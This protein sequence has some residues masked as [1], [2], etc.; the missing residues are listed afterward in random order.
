MKPLTLS[1]IRMDAA[2]AGKQARL[3]RAESLIA[4]A[5]AQGAQMAVLP[6][7]FNTGY[8]YL[9][10]NYQLAE[11]LDGETVH[12][13]KRVARQYNLHV[14][15]TF[16]LRE[17]DGLY[18]AM[19]LIAPDGRV[20]RY[21]KSH[22]W[23]WERAYFQPRKNPIQVAETELGRIGMLICW[24]AAHAALWAQYAGKVDLMLVSSC[25]PL[26]HQLV[27]HLPDGGMVKPGEL[28]ALF[29]FFY[30][31][32][33]KTF[34]ELFRNQ[35]RWLGV[36]SVNTTGAGNFRSHLPR[37]VASLLTFFCLRPDLWKYIPQAE[38]VTV[39]AG[40]FDETF[41]ADANGNVT[42]KTKLDGDD[43]VVST[44]QLSETTPKP[45]R[46]QPAFG[47]N[48]LAYLLDNYSNAMFRSYYNRRWKSG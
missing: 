33:E 21:D 10:Q 17:T 2:P 6:E 23:A 34:G 48:P 4:R 36:P 31:N 47:L 3:A 13:M 32:A 22:P 44:V 16:L 45:D 19:L 43:M 39:S 29:Q 26:A 9:P 20:W 5:A 28:G 42:A 40:Y 11:S 18:N 30:R 37:P 35:A 8:A 1:A 25:P 15:G 38:Q 24:D 27:F 46:P 41:I 7:L 14:A 12:W